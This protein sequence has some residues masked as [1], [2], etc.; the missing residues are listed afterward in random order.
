MKIATYNVNSIRK[1]LPIVLEWLKLHVI[2]SEGGSATDET[3]H[4]EFMAEYLTDAAPGRHHE[5]SVFEKV[6]GE[7][8]YLGEEDETD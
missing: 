2:A 8:L 6:G 1:R 4:V 3:G 7:W 5:C